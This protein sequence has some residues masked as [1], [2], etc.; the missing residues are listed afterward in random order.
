MRSVPTPSAEQM[1]LLHALADNWWLIF[2]RGIA[3]IIFGV[4]AF[5]WPGVTLFTL[6]IL[7]GAFAF[8]DGILAI[9]AAIRGSAYASRWWLAIVGLIGIAAGIATLLW[10]GI[11]GLILLFCIAG[12]AIATGVMQ[13]VG[14]IMMRKEIEGEWLLIASGVLSILF[15]GLLLMQP[16]AGALALVFVIG[17]YAILYGILLISF[18]LRLRAHAGEHTGE[19][20]A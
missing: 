17:S 3:A 8:A 15:G 13:I 12:W 1:P 19:A 7:Y 10:P 11:T 5:L 20:H 6:V 18:S 14:A 2:L 16:G 9:L 4:L